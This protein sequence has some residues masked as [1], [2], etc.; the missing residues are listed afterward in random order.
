MKYLSADSVFYIIMKAREF[1]VKVE[2]ENMGRESDAVDDGCVE[3]LEDYADDATE[4]ELREALVNLNEDQLHELVALMWLGRGTYSKAEWDEA[5][6]E[7]CEADPSAK[8]SPEYLMG[9]PLLSDY[10]EEGL[11]EMGVS[12]EE[13]EV[14]RL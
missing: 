8:S 12:I 2:P 13:F 14:G 10:L 7:A 3:I 11:S 5:I 4:D 9:T 1:D 6:K